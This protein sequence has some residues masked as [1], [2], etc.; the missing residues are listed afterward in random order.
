MNKR[1]PS[2]LSALIFILVLNGCGG[3][4][5][6][7]NTQP[8]SENPLTDPNDATFVDHTNAIGYYSDGSLESPTRLQDSAPGL[9][10]IF[11]LRDRNYATASMV[12]TILLAAAAFHEEFPEGDRIQVGDIAD[13][14]GGFLSGHASHQ[15]G[16]DADIAYLRNNQIE[17]DPDTNGPIGFGESFVINGKI[18]P[19]FDVS[20]NWAIL[21]ELVIRRNVSRIFV[22]PVIKATFCQQAVAVDLKSSAATREE[23]LRRLRQ[24]DGHADHFH[25]RLN[26]PKNHPSCLAQTE[27]P[28]G[29]GCAEV[30]ASALG[31]TEDVRTAAQIADDELG[32]D[33][34]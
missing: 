20:R 19:N 1:I 26:C 32:E 6:S 8:L 14:S 15:N 24:L 17:R 4:A 34:G 11:R 33:E 22:D 27:P 12:R 31:M 23:V 3:S 16:L 13:S 30:G 2:A 25:V 5:P 21:R 29:N 18:T 28:S 10:K 9:V 7:G